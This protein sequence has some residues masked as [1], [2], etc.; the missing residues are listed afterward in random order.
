M[1]NWKS[2]LIGVVLIILGIVLI[3]SGNVNAASVSSL[4]NFALETQFSRLLY[5]SRVTAYGRKQSF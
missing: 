1:K 4:N 2:I 5:L 3:V